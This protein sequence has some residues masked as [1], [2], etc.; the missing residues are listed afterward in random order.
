MPR[1]SCREFH[2]HRLGCVSQ[3]QGEFGGG[4]PPLGL[5][6]QCPSDD[7]DHV[8]R[9]AGHFEAAREIRLGAGGGRDLENVRGLVA[10]PRRRAGQRVQRDRAE[11]EHVAGRNREPAGG[12]GGIGVGR[13]RAHRRHVAE[14]P[15]DAEIGEQRQPDLGEQ[16]VRARHVPVH[17]PG[18]V[19]ICERAPDRRQR[20]DGLPD[21]EAPTARQQRRERP[22]RGEV[23]HQHDRVVEGSNLVQLHHVR[24]VE[25]RQHRGFGDRGLPLRA[26]GEPDAFEGD[27]HAGRGDRGAPHLAGG[28]GAD[29]LLDLVPGQSPGSTCHARRR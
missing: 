22:G 6:A 20:G 13:R 26:F 8:R 18:V 2:G 27:R 11:H 3:L 14:Q 5:E 16:D 7:G 25:R 4:T 23:E 12:Y 29:E 24:V 15:G 17:D 21:R 1:A 28:P 9:R 10:R 19:R